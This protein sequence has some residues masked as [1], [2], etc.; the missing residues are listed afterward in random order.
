MGDSAVGAGAGTRVSAE[1][2]ARGAIAGS[3]LT[4]FV[5][6]SVVSEAKRLKSGNA[7]A[8]A[9]GIVMGWNG[10]APGK[11]AR[12]LSLSFAFAARKSVLYTWVLLGSRV[13]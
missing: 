7:V 6:L 3:V 8:K 1:A 9:P 11:V 12:S 13:T 10:G 4:V 2:C 5:E